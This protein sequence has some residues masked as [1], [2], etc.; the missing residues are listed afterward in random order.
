[1]QSVSIVNQTEKDIINRNR[2]NAIII[3]I[4]VAQYLFSR[5]MHSDEM[6]IVFHEN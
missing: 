6:D 2:R 1:M 3:E 5:V 4:C